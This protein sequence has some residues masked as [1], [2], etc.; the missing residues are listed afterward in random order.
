[1]LIM[2]WIKKKNWNYFQFVTNKKV[3]KSEIHFRAKFIFIYFLSL[4]W[5]FIFFKKPPNPVILFSSLSIIFLN[6][7]SYEKLG[8]GGEVILSLQTDRLYLWRTREEQWFK[9]SQV[10]SWI[11]QR[12]KD[13]TRRNFVYD[14][15]VM[16]HWLWRYSD[17]DYVH[18]R[19]FLAQNSRHAKITWLLT[20]WRNQR[21]RSSEQREPE[22]VRLLWPWGSDSSGS[23]PGAT[24]PHF[25]SWSLVSSKRAER[26]PSFFSS[27]TRSPFWCICRRMSQPPTNSPLRYTCGMVGQLA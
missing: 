20:N 22:W 26:I 11:R 16:R 1:M 13:N 10:H 19:I 9:S 25:E 27:S 17:Y 4:G 14:N 23:L 6:R 5:Q 21:K 3:R 15:L 24:F 7:T 12:A 18:D 8:G 2:A